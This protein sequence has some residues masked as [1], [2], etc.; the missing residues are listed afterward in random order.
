MRCEKSN[1]EK[2][3]ELP[4]ETQGGKNTFGCLVN[5][6]LWLPEGT[7]PYSG[8]KV[9]SDYGSTLTASNS[10]GVMSLRTDQL[11][12]GQ[13]IPLFDNR[14]LFSRDGEGFISTGGSLKISKFDKVKQIIAGT[15]YFTAK[16]AKGDSVVV[17]DGRFDV[18]FP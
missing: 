5:G 13:L 11:T 3:D 15:F 6:E 9:S 12:E 7:F 4:A 17:T 16:N 2:I 1:A 10:T 18:K 8:L 14:A